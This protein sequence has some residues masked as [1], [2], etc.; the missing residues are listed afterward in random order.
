MRDA[1]ARNLC[2]RGRRRGK[3]EHTESRER[4]K[5]R[6]RA[7]AAAGAR[8]RCGRPKDRRTGRARV[9][10]RANSYK[11]EPTLSCTGAGVWLTG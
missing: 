9:S 8:G 6:G 7:L 3:F 2:A 10:K 4:K 5:M 11:S 1:A